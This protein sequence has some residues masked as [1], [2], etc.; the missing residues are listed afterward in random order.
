ME[1]SELG[2]ECLGFEPQEQNTRNQNQVRKQVEN[3]MEKQGLLCAADT[4]FIVFTAF[5]IYAFVR[6]IDRISGFQHF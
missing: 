6:R 4:R 1:V 5:Q 2:R 3:S